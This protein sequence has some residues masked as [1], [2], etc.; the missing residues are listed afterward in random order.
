[1]SVS[2]IVREAGGHSSKGVLERDKRIIAS[3]LQQWFADC[4]VDGNLTGLIVRGTSNGHYSQPKKAIRAEPHSVYLRVRGCFIWVVLPDALGLESE[5]LF[6]TLCLK[7]PD[8]ERANGDEQIKELPQR[9][10]A[11]G[12]E[13]HAV[14]NLEKLIK[15]ARNKHDTFFGPY[16]EWILRIYYQ[17]PMDTSNHFL[18]SDAYNLIR[19]PGQPLDVMDEMFE[20]RILESHHKNILTGAMDA[21]RVWLSEAAVSWVKRTTNEFN[22]ARHEAEVRRQAFEAGRLERLGND[23]EMARLALDQANQ[24]K[25]ER[26]QRM[27]QLETEYEARQV[28]IADLEARLVE[29]RKKQK[30]TKGQLIPKAKADARRS[31]DEVAACQQR[32]TALEREHRR[33]SS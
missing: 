29:L 15:F 10:L 4:E 23:V 6:R 33:R 8:Q 32:V 13:Q 20:H 14:V 24:A 9:E 3:E 7:N 1:M 5:Q 11:K 22:Q 21:V 16:A 25:L 2:F 31:I 19:G 26:E 12:R 18:C 27:V 28:E 30:N 17:V